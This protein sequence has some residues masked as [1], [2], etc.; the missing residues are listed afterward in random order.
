MFLEI[1]WGY[2]GSGEEKL[3]MIVIKDDVVK[4]K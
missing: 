2:L 4:L 1:V 3:I